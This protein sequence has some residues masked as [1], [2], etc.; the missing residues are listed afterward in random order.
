MYHAKQAFNISL[1]KLLGI[2]LLGTIQLI[3]ILHNPSS[4]PDSLDKLVREHNVHSSS[5]HN[6]GE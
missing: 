3:T 2:T 5:H 4:K 1:K 6:P